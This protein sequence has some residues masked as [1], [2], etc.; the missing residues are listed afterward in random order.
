MVVQSNVQVPFCQEYPRLQKQVAA[1]ETES[2]MKAPE[3]LT[4]EQL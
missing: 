2:V 1:P 4:L 3:F